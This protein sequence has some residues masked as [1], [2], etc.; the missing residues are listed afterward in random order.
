M[1]TS[2]KTILSLLIGGM[3]VVGA[4]GCAS[5]AI[6]PV[7]VTTAKAEKKVLSPTIALEGVLVPAQT[8][9]LS[10]RIS[11]QISSVAVKSGDYVKAGQVLVTLD[12]R[13]LNAQ[14]NQAQA[15]LQTAQAGQE[16]VQ[17]QVALAKITLDA[18]QKDYDRTVSLFNSGAVS[19][20]QMDT[21]SDKLNTALRQYENASGPSRSQAKAS[22]NT[23]GAAIGNLKVQL[24][25]AILKSPLSGIVTVQGAVIGETVSPGSPLMTVADTTTLK[26]KGTVPQDLIPFLKMGQ[27]VK[28]TVGIYSDSPVQGALTGI[29]PM[30]VS[31]GELF[32]IEVTLPNDG[33]L[34]P[35]LTAGAAV[36]TAGLERLVIPYAAVVSESGKQIVYV[37]QNGKAVRQEVTLGLRNLQDVIV[38]KGIQAGDIVAVTGSGSLKDQMAVTVSQ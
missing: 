3:L 8:A 28:V 29:G 35:G 15:G 31:T 6:G 5:P 19:Q 17:G 22:M 27:L 32:P 14:L 24:D 37:I 38:M 2:I 10:S 13:A 1:K 9:E 18:A 11:G 20:S 33:R 12:D 7:A 23:A 30:A 21:A 25:Y 4:V 34:M 16:M 36:E 26:L